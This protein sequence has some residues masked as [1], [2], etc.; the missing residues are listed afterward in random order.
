[1]IKKT[2]FLLVLF[3]SNIY[4]QEEFFGEQNGV[5]IAYLK[6]FNTSFENINGAGLSAYFKKG[7]GASVGCQ[8]VDNLYSPLVSVFFYTNKFS[9][10]NTLLIA[11]GFTYEQ[12]ES[13]NF[14]GFTTNLIKCF[15]C[16]SSHPASINGL[17]SVFM[18]LDMKSRSANEYIGTN[19]KIIPV[20]G[21]G[22]KQSFF[23]NKTVYPIIGISD[24][25]NI[26]GGINIFSV[27]IGLNIKLGKESG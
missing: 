15:F 14:A 21:L 10:T 3:S 11:N 9:K 19:E 23:T 20:V 18:S 13:Y 7:I 6:G 1:M 16:K 26:S 2:F 8:V 27:N 12:T 17:I 25:Y 4:C 24:A 22:Y 5:S